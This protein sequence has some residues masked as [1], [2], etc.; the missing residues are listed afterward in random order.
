MAEEIKVNE[1]IG[2]VIQSITQ[3]TEQKEITKQRENINMMKN[4]LLKGSSDELVKYVEERMSMF[5]PEQIKNM[6]EEEFDKEFQ[7][8]GEKIRFGE[9]GKF[10]F[11]RDL[12]HLLMVNEET[13]K[14][15]DD[16]LKNIE[17]SNKES[18]IE[19]NKI[20]DQYGSMSAIL[21]DK[22]KAD[23]ENLTDHKLKK[24]MEDN[25][26]YY[27]DGLKLEEFEKWCLDEPN[28]IMA[29]LYYDEMGGRAVLDRF[30]RIAIKHKLPINSDN[31]IKCGNLEILNLPTEYHKI[32]NLFLFMWM[33]YASNILD[34]MS[35]HKKSPL[36]LYV[37]RIAL[38]IKQSTSGGGID[39]KE[40][41]EFIQSVKRILDKKDLSLYKEPVTIDE[42]D[43][44]TE[45]VLLLDQECKN[46]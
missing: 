44:P 37:I 2:K 31:L 4:E 43:L 35:I 7:F 30:S 29:S 25:I 1:D 22:M 21:R 33:R 8:N 36:K 46:E 42:I 41:D 5:T 16:A 6:T 28:D 39:I 11:T 10:N 45:E 3:M 14:E 20:L 27:D 24:Q 13:G 38:L 32:N 19:L 40:K 15:I 17:E 12:I 18:Q 34:N 23:L 26:K 9:D